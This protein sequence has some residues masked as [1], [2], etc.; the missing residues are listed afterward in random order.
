MLFNCVSV[1]CLTH[2]CASA[3]AQYKLADQVNIKY[4]QQ[5]ILHQLSEGTENMLM[6]LVQTNYTLLPTL[7]A[8]C[9][10]I[11]FTRGEE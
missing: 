5:M 8:F 11:G 4:L 3:I 1:A 9:H 2:C 6:M 10:H 7:H